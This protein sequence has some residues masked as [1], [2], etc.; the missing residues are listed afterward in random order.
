MGR[1]LRSLAG[2]A[3]RTGGPTLPPWRSGAGRVDE[4]SAGTLDQPGAKGSRPG[5]RAAGGPRSAPVVG[6]GEAPEDALAHGAAHHPPL[7]RFAP[8]AR[9]QH[10]AVERERAPAGARGAA[11]LSLVGGEL[12]APADVVGMRSDGIGGP[13]VHRDVE[14]KVHVGRAVVDD[15]LLAIALLADQDRLARDPE[16]DPPAGGGATAV[17]TGVKRRAGERPRRAG[18]ERPE[19]ERARQPDAGGG[20]THAHLL[21][22]GTVRCPAGR[23]TG[24]VFAAVPHPR[25]DFSLSRTK[26]LSY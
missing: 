25:R 10:R 23:H 12:L 5:H 21:P 6:V 8:G 19:R 1:L 14:A 11:V 20:M 13:S 17:D 15:P 18:G 24:W 7:R 3:R 2:P 26:N 9:D 4:L 22:E 16:R